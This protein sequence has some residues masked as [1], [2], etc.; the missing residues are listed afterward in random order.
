MKMKFKD[1]FLPKILRSDPETRKKAIS[2]EVNIE[3]LKQV[4]EKD[5]DPDVRECARLRIKEIEPKTVT[6]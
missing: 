5:T 1:M 4:I 3:L 2:Q 6:A